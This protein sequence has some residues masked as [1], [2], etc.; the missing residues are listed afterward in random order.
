MT[1]YLTYCDLA[2]IADR[3]DCLATM[4]E[5]ERP[6]SRLVFSPEFDTARAW[7]KQQFLA[8]GLIC[9]VDN[10]GSLI[11]VRRGKKSDKK[12]VLGS[13]IDTVPAGG[14]FD[15][16]AGVLAALEVVHHLNDAEIDLPFD[17]EIADYLGEEL[18]VWGT[19]CLG[20]RHMAGLVTAEMLERVDA[21]GRRLGDEIVR[22][23]GSGQPPGERR[24][25]ADNIIACLELHIEQATNLESN[26]FDI[27]VVTGIPGIYR[28]AIDVTGQAG[29][30]GTTQMAG[31]QDALV[32]AAD[33]IA[34]TNAL[35]TAIASDDNQHFVATIGKIDVFPN[36]AAIVPGVVQM[37]LDLRAASAQGRRQ[38]LDQFETHLA[39]VRAGRHCAIEFRSLAAAPPAPMDSGLQKLLTARAAALGLKSM[40]ISSGAGHD[41]AHLS[42]IAPAA[43][44]F[45]PCRDGLSHCPEEFA[46]TESIAKGA[47]VL[48]QAVLELAVNQAVD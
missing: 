27:G 43:M 21:D 1:D 13:H 11:G 14:R 38:F 47:A 19:S 15:G 12:V 45:I 26:G 31:R 28:Y 36:G 7:L 2:R 8:A 17:L 35:A 5:P 34:A 40:P 46:T 48:A 29:H 41:T 44:I 32:A 16:I 25:D 4:T 3:I 24:S 37:T 9:H 42:R 39:S 30:S 18:N 6:Y 10:G 22:V 23:G 33:I 20:S